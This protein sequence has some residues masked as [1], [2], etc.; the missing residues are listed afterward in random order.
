VTSRTE[1][2][3]VTAPSDLARQLGIQRGDVMLYFNSLLYAENGRVVDLS[4]S[5]FLPGYFRFHVVRRV[6]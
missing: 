2:N 3:A 1:I 5:Y 6:G 4:Q